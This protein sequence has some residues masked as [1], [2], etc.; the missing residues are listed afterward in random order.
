M[1]LHIFT[2]FGTIK[3][4]G[5]IKEPKNT[6]PNGEIF[7][8]GNDFLDLGVALGM[9]AF[10]SIH[11]SIFVLLPLSSVIS[12]TNSKKA[13]WVMFG[14]RA[15]VLLFFDFFITTGIAIVDFLAVFVGAFIVVPLTKIVNI[16]GGIKLR[17][18]L[19]TLN[20]S[21]DTAKNVRKSVAKKAVKPTDFDPIFSL[22]EDA[23]IDSFLNREMQRAQ[24]TD[25][26]G[27]IPGELLRRKNI[28]NTIYAGLIYIY[29]ALIFFHRSI[30]IYIVGLAI[31]IVYGIMTSRYRLMKYIKKEVKSRPQEKISNIVMNV[32]ASL[33]ADYSGKL[34]AA[35][36][37]AAVALALITFAKP[38]IMYEKADDGY[39]VRF[40]TFG[41]T[42]MTTASIPEMY[43]GEKVVGLRGNT[44]SNMPLLRE[45]TLPDTITE[46]RG[47]AFQNC[48]MLTRVELPGKLVYLGGGAF[49]NCKF[50]EEIVLPDTL[51]YL[52]GESFYGCSSLTRAKLS[53][54]LTEI[55]G[56]T[57]EECSSLSRIEIPDGVTRIGGHAFYGNRSLSEV[58][59]SPQSKLE[60]IGSSA[61]RCCDSLEEITLPQGVDI[62][63]RAFKETNATIYFYD[64]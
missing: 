9:E 59:I 31:L 8:F 17:K 1:D 25:V 14:I 30:I 12:K 18:Q 3:P 7:M 41:L 21:T 62:N 51:T 2:I 43:Q 45:V 60:E 29:I 47:Q 35:L 6:V 63:E 20:K 16:K 53:A 34:K 38:R 32:K 13:F 56:N 11:M 28:L 22:S 50:L 61:F 26:K 52:G 36:I 55:R 58:L 40:Y 44:F 46:I 33:V 42:N 4:W 64:E 5:T 54:G 48:L 49:Y 15:A 39:N 23:C 27:L 19:D 37:F 24:I 57:F 10:V